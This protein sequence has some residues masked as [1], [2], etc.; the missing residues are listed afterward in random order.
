M[1]NRPHL[2]KAGQFQ[3]VTKSPMNH[4]TLVNWKLINRPNKEGSVMEE[5]DQNQTK[6]L[7][8]ESYTQTTNPCNQ[9]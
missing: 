3:M 1:T 5:Q 4:L 6:L 9:S 8:D 2:H 7:L